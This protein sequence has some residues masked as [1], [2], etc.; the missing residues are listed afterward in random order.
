[1]TLTTFFN[2]VLMRPCLALESFTVLR[3]LRA[4][5]AVAELC[6][7]ATVA[8]AARRNPAGQNQLPYHD[9]V[10]RERGQPEDNDELAEG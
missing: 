8:Q 3:Q 6:D 9:A 5:G 4:A 2:G 1:M 10:H 7:E